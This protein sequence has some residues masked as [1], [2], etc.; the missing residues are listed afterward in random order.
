MVGLPS[1]S[2]YKYNED[3][4]RLHRGSFNIAWA[5]YSFLEALDTLGSQTCSDY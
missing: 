3:S 4:G 1:R 2:K 5:K